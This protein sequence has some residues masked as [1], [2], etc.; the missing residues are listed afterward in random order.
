MPS[1]GIHDSNEIAHD[2]VFG[3]ISEDGPDCR[4]VSLSWEIFHTCPTDIAS[5]SDGLDPPFP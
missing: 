3:E 5:R 4:N 2:P 1:Q